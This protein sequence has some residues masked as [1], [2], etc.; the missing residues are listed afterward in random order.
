MSK[1][2]PIRQIRSTMNDD[3]GGNVSEMNR[4]TTMVGSTTGGDEIQLDMEG[5]S[6][7]IDLNAADDSGNDKESFYM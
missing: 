7:D 4:T 1:T 6:S 3:D 2:R 5:V